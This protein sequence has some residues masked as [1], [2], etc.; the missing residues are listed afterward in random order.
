[1]YINKSTKYSTLWGETTGKNKYIT[2]SCLTSKDINT[3]W[4]LLVYDNMGGETNSLQVTSNTN[5]ET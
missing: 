2:G 4:T 3:D 1:M 5:R